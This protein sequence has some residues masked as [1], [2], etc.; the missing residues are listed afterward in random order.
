[1]EAGHISD[2]PSDSSEKKKLK[3]LKNSV[4]QLIRTTLNVPFH[5]TQLNDNKSDLRMA[6]TKYLAI[7]DT[8][9]CLDKMRA[10]G[11][12]TQKSTLTDVVEV[13]MSKSVYHRNPSKI[14]PLVPNYPLME[15]WLLNT[16]DAPST[17]KVWKGKKQTY[18]NLSEILE[19]H[20][21]KEGKSGSSSDKKGKKH[22]DDPPPASSK[23]KE[24]KSGSS[25]D[26]KGKKRQD[27]PPPASSKAKKHKDDSPDTLDKTAK[28]KKEKG[29]KTGDSNKKVSSSKS[30]D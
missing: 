17:A 30:R 22:Q 18:E 28:K 13:F 6:Y 16:D 20:S 8:V 29:K 21:Q 24:G 27:D 4:S 26:K 19:L 11:T 25:S 5:L 15:Q 14:F 2:S 9:E 10:A 12:W 7:L 3:K 23:A 1:M